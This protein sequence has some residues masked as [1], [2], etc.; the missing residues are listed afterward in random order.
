[1]IVQSIKTLGFK[2]EDIKIIINGHGHADHA[3]AFA[4]M[5]Q[6]T[7]VWNTLSDYQPRIH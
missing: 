3:G 5:K 6:L 7:G 1:M 2:P 4:Y